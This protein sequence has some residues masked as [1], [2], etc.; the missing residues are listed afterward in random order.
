MWAAARLHPLDP[1]RA[2][3]ECRRRGGEAALASALAG[4]GASVE[5]TP[6]AARLRSVLEGVKPA[7]R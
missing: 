2:R 4:L 1:E 5:P 6:D 3:A 7:E